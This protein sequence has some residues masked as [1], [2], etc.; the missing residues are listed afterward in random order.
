[1]FRNLISRDVTKVTEIKPLQVC[2]QQ[3]IKEIVYHLAILKMKF[4]YSCTKISQI[5]ACNLITKSN[6]FLNV[7]AFILHTAP[8]VCY[9]TYSEEPLSN[10][11]FIF[12]SHVYSVSLHFINKRYTLH[13][14]LRNVNRQKEP[15]TI[16]FLFYRIQRG[17]TMVD[18]EGHQFHGHLPVGK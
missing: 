13:G 10:T 1:M 8:C 9:Y 5:N 2:L 12:L 16:L 3:F 11:V 18:H 7:L 6:R 17:C 15:N 14:Y 4:N